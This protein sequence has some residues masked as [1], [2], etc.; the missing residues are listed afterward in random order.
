LYSCWARQ[1]G[2][3]KAATGKCAKFTGKAILQE[4][5]KPAGKCPNDTDTWYANVPIAGGYDEKSGKPLTKRKQGS[6]SQ[7]LSTKI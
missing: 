4:Y 1:K 7:L 2:Y 5:W 6:I 3:R